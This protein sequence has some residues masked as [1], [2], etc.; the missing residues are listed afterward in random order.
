MDY[1][2][3][4][5][6]DYIYAGDLKGNLWRFEPHGELGMRA[7]FLG[8]SAVQRRGPAQCRRGLRRTPSVVNSP[9]TVRPEVIRHPVRGVMVLFGTGAYYRKAD[10]NPNKCIVNSLYGIWDKLDGTSATDWTS[11]IGRDHLLKQ[12]ILATAVVGAFDVRVV[13]DNP[14]AWH[15]DTGKSRSAFPRQPIWV[16]TLIFANPWTGPLKG[17]SRSQ[18]LGHT[19]IGSSSPP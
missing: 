11:D 16:G 3:D 8:A 13:S 4:G 7:S 6:I 10:R 15:T 9:I 1:Q 19:A 5:R 18:T 17:R 12:Q 14:I 2:R